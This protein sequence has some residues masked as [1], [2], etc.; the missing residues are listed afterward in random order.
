MTDRRPPNPAVIE[1][2]RVE[3]PEDLVHHANG[4]VLVLLPGPIKAAFS[5]SADDARRFA[6]ALLEEA[7]VVDLRELG[8]IDTDTYN[9]LMG[10]LPEEP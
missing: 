7:V 1:V 3:H 9:T 10:S 5:M 4:H 2:V 8:A 6:M